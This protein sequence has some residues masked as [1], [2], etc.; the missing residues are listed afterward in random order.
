[1]WYALAVRP[2][3]S[4]I[5]EVTATLRTNGGNQGFRIPNS[6]KPFIFWFVN[7][8]STVHDDLLR[9]RLLKPICFRRGQHTAPVLVLP[10]KRGG[11]REQVAGPFGLSPAHRTVHNAIGRGWNRFGLQRESTEPPQSL[12]AGNR[13]GSQLVR[14][15][16]Q[17]LIRPTLRLKNDRSSEPAE[18]VGPSN[19]PLDLA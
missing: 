1:M 8:P 6:L 2:E 5:G 15:Q 14:T 12:T 11:E 18:H 3:G 13:I 7:H 16:N 19:P 17:H 10:L 4:A 9:R